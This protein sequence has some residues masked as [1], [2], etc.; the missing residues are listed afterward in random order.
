MAAM[1]SE[2]KLTEAYI[3]GVLR[4]S[5][6]LTLPLMGGAILAGWYA[7]GAD[8]DP[9]VMGIF[10]LIV[11]VV[12]ALSMRQNLRRQRAQLRTLRIGVDETALTRTQEGLTPLTIRF[13][14]ITR[15]AEVPGKGLIVRGQGA[16]RV[17]FLPVELEGFDELRARLATVRPIEPGKPGNSHLRMWAPAVVVGAL[18]IVVYRAESIGWVLAAGGTLSVGLIVCGVMIARSMHVD[19]RVKWANWGIVIV[20]LGLALR[21]WLVVT[22]QP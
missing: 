21:M 3:T 16:E 13:A 22:H 2:H 5:L 19:R 7:A 4:K 20:V 9:T 12:L 14:E 11:A 18:L 10:G 17:L 8:T 6:R 1:P 15:L